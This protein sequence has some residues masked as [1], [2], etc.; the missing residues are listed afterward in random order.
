MG[1]YGGREALRHVQCFE[2]SERLFFIFSLLRVWLDDKIDDNTISDVDGGIVFAHSVAKA[3]CVL[4]GLRAPGPGNGANTAPSS[5]PL[6]IGSAAARMHLSSFRL[7]A[8]S[9]VQDWR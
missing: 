3:L 9:R 2:M 7:S 1:E 4:E 8:R 6:L 5:L